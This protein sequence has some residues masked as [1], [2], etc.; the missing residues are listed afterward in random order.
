VIRPALLA[1]LACAALVPARGGAAPAAVDAPRKSAVSPSVRDGRVEA[2]VDLSSALPPDLERQLG[3]G[4]TNVVAL[5]VALLPERGGAPVAIHAREVQVL[6]D[7]WEETWGVVVRDPAA[8]RGRRVR[9]ASF[10]ELRRFLSGVDRVALGPVDA[11]GP[12]RFFVQARLE[13]N[14]ISRE[15]VERTRELLAN[16]AQGRGGPSRSVLGAFAGYLLRDPPPGAAVRLLRSAPF[17]AGDL[18]A[19]R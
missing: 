3:N 1:A 10:P 4:L 17:A 19:P 16:P 5:H 14:P 6:F 13:V 2:D 8:P 12:G 18:G 11:L 15:L 7:V 9:F